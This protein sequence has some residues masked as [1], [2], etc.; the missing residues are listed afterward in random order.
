ML[1]QVIV[2]HVL[3]SVIDELSLVVLRL[4]GLL[5]QLLVGNT[6]LV[7]AALHLLVALLVRIIQ[8]WI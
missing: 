2:H 3:G 6:S 1:I 4:L 5:V 7:T 8:Y